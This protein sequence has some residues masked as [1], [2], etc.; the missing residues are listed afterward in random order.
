VF[1]R[2]TRWDLLAARERRFGP[3]A[4]QRRHDDMAL[5]DR[6][7]RADFNHGRPP[8]AATTR[9]TRFQGRGV[10]AARAAGG[11][12]RRRAPQ[13][14]MRGMRADRPTRRFGSRP[15]A[16]F[17]HRS[18]QRFQPHRAAVRGRGRRPGPHRANHR[19]P[20]RA[21]HEPRRDPGR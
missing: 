7:L 2:P 1:A 5:H 8:I 12:Y 13:Q 18:A 16:R 14:R 9:A 6:A 10:F 11:P 19:P 4:L 15:E 17:S 21:N 20:H 3:N